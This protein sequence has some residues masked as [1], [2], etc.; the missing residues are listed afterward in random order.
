MGEPF[1]DLDFTDA[2]RRVTGAEPD[3]GLEPDRRFAGGFVGGAGP[4]C[5]GRLAPT[6]P[7]LPFPPP[8]LD[9]PRDLPLPCFGL[10]GK[11]EAM[12]CIDQMYEQNL[13]R[14]IQERKLESNPIPHNK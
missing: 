6:E 4:A 3:D 1:F 14:N 11:K 10:Q 8:V 12:Q 2:D 7:L 5:G 13:M 9:R